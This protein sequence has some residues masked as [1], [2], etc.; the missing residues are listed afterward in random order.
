MEEEDIKESVKELNAIS[1]DEDEDAREALEE[2]E[3]IN[4]FFGLKRMDDDDMK[5]ERLVFSINLTNLP[6]I[7]DIWIKF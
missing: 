3:E 2:E 5:V 1:L 7:Y 6:G 4:D